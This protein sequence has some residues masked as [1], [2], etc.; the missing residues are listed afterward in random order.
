MLLDPIK[1]YLITE[2]S[3]K[4]QFVEFLEVLSSLSP[5]LVLS[6]RENFAEA[7]EIIQQPLSNST[8]LIYFS[9]SE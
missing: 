7:A 6:A 8:N 1:I 3:K 2:T 5:A 9:I 4:T